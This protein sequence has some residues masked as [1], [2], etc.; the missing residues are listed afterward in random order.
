MLPRVILHNTVSLDGAFA[1]FD[2]DLG[3]H[4]ARAASLR[5]DA[6][7]IGADTARTGVEAF[8]GPPPETAELRAPPLP[9]PGDRRP[10]WVIVDSRGQC[11]GLLHA[12]RG[13]RYCR[14]VAVLISE[15]TP[16][17]YTKYLD[18]RGYLRW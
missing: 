3:A 18:S 11:E 14:D 10:L 16:P 8:G 17:S 9:D 1:G 2:V 5:P 7:L 4:Y 12:F 15:R 13:S 6:H